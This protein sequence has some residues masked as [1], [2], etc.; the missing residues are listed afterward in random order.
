MCNF[1]CCCSHKMLHFT[2]ASIHPRYR[3]CT[4]WL[5]HQCCEFVW[6]KSTKIYSHTFICA[7]MNTIQSRN[8]FQSQVFPYR[9]FPARNLI[10]ILLLLAICW[11][12]IYIHTYTHRYIVCVCLFPFCNFNAVKHTLIWQFSTSIVRAAPLLQLQCNVFIL[13]VVIISTYIHICI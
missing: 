8:T 1:S 9:H 11:R 3:L 12:S 4:A 6:L 13:L 2:A 10:Q 5:Q 7:H